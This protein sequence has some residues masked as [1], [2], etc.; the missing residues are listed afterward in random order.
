M[1]WFLAMHDP[2]YPVLFLA[3]DLFCPGDLFVENKV[4]RFALSGRLFGLVLHQLESGV[5]ARGESKFYLDII[6]NERRKK[7]EDCRGTLSKTL[8]LYQAT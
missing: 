6:F 8:L 2:I 7:R 4:V 1:A 3:S 5:I